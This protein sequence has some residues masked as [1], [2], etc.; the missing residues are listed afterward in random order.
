MSKSFEGTEDFSVSIS[1]AYIL[2]A[3]MEFLGMNDLDD[4]PSKL[5]PPSGIFHLLNTRKTIY[6]GE[7]IGSF[8]DTFVMAHPDRDTIQQ[9]QELQH[10]SL[11][12]ATI[13]HD[14]E[15]CGAAPSDDV[16]GNGANDKVMEEDLGGKDKVR[17]V[18]LH[19]SGGHI[20]PQD[21]NRPFYQYSS[22]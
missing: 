12:V 7:V 4:N 10:R 13:D 9:N 15:Y 3:A 5:K 14:H 2:E 1:K 21:N 6:F 8:T 16:L 19:F 18:N 17:H 11:Q 20:F 22:H